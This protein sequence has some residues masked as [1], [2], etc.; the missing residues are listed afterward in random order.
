MI[1]QFLLAV[2]FTITILCVFLI[3]NEM[4]KNEEDE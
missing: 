1:G 2:A 4:C 3:I